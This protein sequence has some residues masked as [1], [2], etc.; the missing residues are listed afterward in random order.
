MNGSKQDANK[1]VSLYRCRN[2]II[3]DISIIHGGWF[4]ILAAGVDNIAIDNLKIDTNRDAIDIDCC[5]NVRVSNLFINSLY[6]DGICLKSSFA[7]GYARPTENVT[8][9]NC[10]LS[11]Y[12]E[13]T[14]LDGTYKRSNRKN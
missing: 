1:F 5:K 2:V 11:G 9:T 7:L 6:D 8:I 12:D 4:A 10:Q 14:L 3:R 13:G